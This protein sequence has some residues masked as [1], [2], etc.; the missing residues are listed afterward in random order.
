MKKSKRILSLLL[1]V[2]TGIGAFGGLGAT[3][4]HAA[5]EMSVYMVGL[6]RAADPNKDGW[7]HPALSYMNGWSTVSSGSFTAKAMGGYD[8]QTVYCIE[9]GVSLNTGDSFGSQG[10]G[11]WDNYPSSLNNTISP[12]VMRAYVGRIL[13]YG[14]TGNNNLNWNSNNPTHRQ[15]IAEQIATQTLIWETIVGE[16]DSQFGK[17]NANSQGKNNIAET[18]AGNHP[19]RG[20][21]FSH[22]NRIEK[23]VEKHTKLPSFFL[24]VPAV[25]T[26][27]NWLGTVQITQL[28]WLTRMMCWTTI[29][30]Q[31]IQQD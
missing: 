9:P 27:W 12:A 14:W 21:I 1:A 13:Q 19:L 17:V 6:P 20:E 7:G 22:Y 10:E 2:L 5:S 11:F 15:E 31:A 8:G 3:T 28:R 18:I 30:F 23:A 16:R 26:L 29:A 25:Q 24:E 4:V